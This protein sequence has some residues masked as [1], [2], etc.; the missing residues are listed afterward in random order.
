MD[1]LKAEKWEGWSEQE[2][3]E[4]EDAKKNYQYYRKN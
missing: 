2:K 1:L 3:A 4:F